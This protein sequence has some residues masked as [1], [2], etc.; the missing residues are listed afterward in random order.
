MPASFDLRGAAVGNLV[1][2][3]GY[4]SQ[5]R[6]L[7]SVLYLFSQ[8]VEARGT[9]RPVLEQNLHLVGIL[10][11]GRRV[12][13]QHLLT[14]KEVPPLEVPVREVF[15]SRSVTRPKPVRPE[16]PRS[17]A[18]LIRGADLIC[19]PIGSFYTSLVATLLP[20]GV[21][22][23]IADADGPKVYVPNGGD[24]PEE[25]GMGILDKIS[26]LLRTLRMDLES[27]E[28]AR[29]L[30]QFVMID[31]RASPLDRTDR[32]ALKKLGVELVEAPLVTSRSAPY[33]DDRLL[34]EALL[35]LI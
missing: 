6:S 34:V 4:L 22:R 23:A 28:S 32:A 24:D 9:V 25:I 18:E 11:D 19:Y 15:L 31:T 8:L 16:I 5:N 10:A 26:V 2:A 12:V 27:D 17:V 20:G 13:G 30:L 33:Y 29:R 14:G 35:S 21:G 3:G 1:L 7:D